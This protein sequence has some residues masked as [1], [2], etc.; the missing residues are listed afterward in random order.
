MYS[1][2]LIFH[3]LPGKYFK[4]KRSPE[5]DSE[6]LADRKGLKKERRKTEVII[7]E[8]LTKLYECLQQIFHQICP[9]AKELIT[10]QCYLTHENN[11]SSSGDSRHLHYLEN[12]LAQQA[13]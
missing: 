3:L 7:V 11:I 13:Q 2:R 9:Q 12:M 8:N 6:I 4:S 1:Y 5:A 10:R